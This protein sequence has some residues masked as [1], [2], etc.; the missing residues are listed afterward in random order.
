MRIVFLGVQNNTAHDVF[1]YKPRNVSNFTGTR[2]QS[3]S[4]NATITSTGLTSSAIVGLTVHNAN[5]ALSYGVLDI[6]D[7]ANTTLY[8]AIQ[9]TEVYISSD[10]FNITNFYN[11]GLYAVD[12]IDSFTIAVPSGSLSSGTI[13][14]Y[15]V[16]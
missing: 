15:G 4:Q 5:S 6:F 2:I 7:Y 13:K 10:P 11:G 16:N 1:Q 3:T 12:A 9:M 8:K 14:V